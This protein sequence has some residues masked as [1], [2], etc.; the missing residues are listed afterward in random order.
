M[1]RIYFLLLFFT[2]LNLLAT[3]SNTGSN[4]PHQSD[5]IT[6]MPWVITIISLGITAWQVYNTKQVAKM[7]IEQAQQLAKF[8]HTSHIVSNNRMEYIRELREA[9]TKMILITHK[10]SDIIEKEDLTG[11]TEKTDINDKIL[12]DFLELSAKFQ[13]LLNPNEHLTSRIH[14]SMNLIIDSIRK[15]N[16]NDFNTGNKIF[17]NTMQEILKNEWEKIK[18]INV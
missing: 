17:I 16:S 3:S 11:L 1:K 9:A 18:V 5:L 2:P 14:T 6:F 13:L 10:I 7:Q 12:D 8:T 15:H 4:S